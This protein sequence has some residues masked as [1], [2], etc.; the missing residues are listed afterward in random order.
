[1]EIAL[2]HGQEVGFCKRFCK[3]IEIT[4]IFFVCPVVTESRL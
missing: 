1:M 4:E 2:K 3:I